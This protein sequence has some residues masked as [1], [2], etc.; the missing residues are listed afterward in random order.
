MHSDVSI[1]IHAPIDVVFHWIDNPECVMKWLRHLA[2][3]DR[4]DDVGIKEG[5]PIHQVWDD[6]GKRT[7]INGHITLYEPHTELGFFLEGNGFSI[8]VDYELKEQDGS[9]RLTQRTKI[10]YKGI[11]RLI[12][13]VA[14]K[15]LE[16]SYV[17]ELKVNFAE[18]TELCEAEGA[19]AR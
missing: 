7:N 11:L 10:E 16:N 5:L 15:Y 4:P 2:Q 1:V 12:S 6:N 13:L 9:T 3:Y 14:A 18:L 8:Q 17:K 19:T